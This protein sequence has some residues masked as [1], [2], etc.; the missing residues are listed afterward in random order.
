VFD[1]GSYN[2]FS[3][4]SYTFG[5]FPYNIEYN[6]DPMVKVESLLDIGLFS[7]NSGAT[8]ANEFFLSGIFYVSNLLS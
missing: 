3:F 6:I 2:P 8:N 1:S 4:I 5:Y 7:N